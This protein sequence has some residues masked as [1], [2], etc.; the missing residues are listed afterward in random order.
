[1]KVDSNHNPQQK[2]YE[3]EAKQT[4][5]QSGKSNIKEKHYYTFTNN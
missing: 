3:S 5:F 1:M 2:K 4:G